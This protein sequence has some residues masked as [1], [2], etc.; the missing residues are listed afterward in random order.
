[1]SPFAHACVFELVK[2]KYV[3]QFTQHMQFVHRTCNA[4]SDNIGY[5]SQI[6]GQ[7][8]IYSYRNATRSFQLFGHHRS[9]GGSCSMSFSRLSV[10]STSRFSI[11]RSL[12]IARNSALFAFMRVARSMYSLSAFLCTRV[13]SRS[14]AAGLTSSPVPPC[15][16]VSS[17]VST[18]KILVSLF[19]I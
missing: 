6:Y 11:L 12:F 14:S 1:M 18:I 13:E 10:H 15:C 5:I 16:S 7:K 8:R 17:T 19:D 2:S 3:D 9:G 4:A